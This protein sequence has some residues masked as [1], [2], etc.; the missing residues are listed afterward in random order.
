MKI[1]RWNKVP[2]AAISLTQPDKDPDVLSKMT[3]MD[4]EET[5]T[6]GL[7]TGQTGHEKSAVDV[8]AIDLIKDAVLLKHS[9]VSILLWYVFQVYQH[10]VI[11]HH[12]HARCR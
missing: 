5:E 9:L 6:D 7:D 1:A 11:V 4:K 10:L 2:V 3:S 8:K 12:D